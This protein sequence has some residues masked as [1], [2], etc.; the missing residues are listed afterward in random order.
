MSSHYTWIRGDEPPLLKRHSEVKHTLLRD[1]LVSY[2]LTLVPM[3]QQDRIQL[4]IVDGFCGGGLYKNEVSEEVVGSPLVILE[5]IKEAKALIE[6]RQDRRKPL[7]VDVELICIDQS[8]SALEHLRYVLEARSY[9]QELATGKIKLIQGSFA[10]HCDA[11]IERARQRSRIAGRALFILDQYGYTAVPVPCLSA[12]FANLKRAEIILTFAV[13]ALLTFLDSKNL[14]AF[15][16][17][18]GLNTTIKASDLDQL[19]K[20]PRWRGQLQSELYN[21]LTSQSGAHFYTPFF[22]RPD[23]GH[24]DFWLLHLSQHWKARDVMANAHWEHNNHFAHYALAGFDMFATGYIGKLDDGN[25]LQ[26]GFDFSGVA[27][28]VSQETMA[29]QIPRMLF[30]GADGISFEQ[31]FLNVINTTPATQ[32]MVKATILELHQHGE[33]RIVDGR[34]ETSRARAHIK[35]NHSL[36]LPAQQTFLF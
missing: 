31:F 25:K 13:D 6:I 12:I 14:L 7:E 4:T 9:G 30:D 36:R 15:K 24:G 17:N 26:Q 28:Q 19:K 33:I 27:A 5:S 32:E 22:I 23:H 16:R 2:F 20:S 1:Y 35:P 34:G 10:E 11:V 3:P 8:K 21:S 29:E 18:T